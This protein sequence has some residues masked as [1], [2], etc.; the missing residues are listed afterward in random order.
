[1]KKK[2]MRFMTLLLV[3]V[4]MGACGP[5]VDNATLDDGNGGR[6]DIRVTATGVDEN[7]CIT[8]LVGE[9]LQLKVSYVL[10]NAATPEVLFYTSDD[11][12]ATV[13]PEGL[14]TTVGTG[15]VEIMAV[16]AS[17]PDAVAK[18]TVNVVNGMVGLSDIA[19]DKSEAEARRR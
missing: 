3:A 6:R 8:L 5:F 14:V 18:I 11:R 7:G 17:N 16:N 13:T 10:V 2:M 19:V 12:I 15:V 1:M 4:V 9:Q